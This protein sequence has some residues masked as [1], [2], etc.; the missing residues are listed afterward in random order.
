MQA[1]LHGM[2]LAMGLILPLGVQ[3]LFVFTQG[4]AQPTFLR[5]LPV[6]ITASLCDTLLIVLAVQG[7]SLFIASFAWIKI[8]F[9][10][11]GVGFLAYMGWLTW[12]STWAGNDAGAGKRLGVKQQI[13]FA[14][15]VSL[16]NPHAVLDTIG[17][18]GT[19][20]IHYIGNEKIV[21]TM[22]CILVSWCWFFLLAV[23]GWNVGKKK[24]FTQLF[25]Y[26]NKVSSIFMWLSAAYMMYNS[27]L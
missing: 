18:I 22:A 5:A 10:M 12:N 7:V 14:V 20:A 2:I 21:F 6:V 19:S 17:V 25:G 27:V 24:S 13:V 8:I 26:I 23:I 9:L 3:N 1:F 15:T 16:F 4:A 11:I